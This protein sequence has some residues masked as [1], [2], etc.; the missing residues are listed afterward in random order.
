MTVNRGLATPVFQFRR[1]DLFVPD[2]IIVN[3]ELV[4]GFFRLLLLSA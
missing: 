4:K 2:Q 3:S 1:H